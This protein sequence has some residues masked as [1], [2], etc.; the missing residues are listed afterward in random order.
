MGMFDTINWAD[1]LPFSQEMVELGLDKNSNSY[2][3]KDLENALFEYMVQGGKLFLK[4]FR[5]EEWIEGDPKSDSVMGRI[6]HMSRTDE[7]YEE[8]D[9]G[10]RTIRMYDYRED[11]QGK[12]DCFVEFDVV[13]VKGVISEVKLVSFEKTDNSHRKEQHRQWLERDA[14]EARLWYNRF[15]FRTKAWRKIRR[16]IWRSLQSTGQF[17]SSLSHKI[18]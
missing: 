6:G 15:I 8:I 1:S 14:A 13:I 16:P 10:T 18:P 5:N 11:V 9:V 7:Y 12:W 3:T 4:R 17:L 2:Q